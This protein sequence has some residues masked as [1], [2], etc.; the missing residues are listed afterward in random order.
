MRGRGYFKEIGWLLDL[1]WFIEFCREGCGA[2][3]SDMFARFQQF[4]ELQLVDFWEFSGP[5][6]IRR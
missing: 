1:G 6:E 4:W 2:G 3:A 5:R